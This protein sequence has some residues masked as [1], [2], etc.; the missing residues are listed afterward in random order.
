MTTDIKYSKA[1]KR[2]EE[3]IQKIESE[4]IDVD[5]LSEKVKEAIELITVC[6]GKIQKAEVDVKQVVDGFEK[7]VSS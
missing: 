4:E 7:T 6:K 3:I 1:L 5:E 2:L